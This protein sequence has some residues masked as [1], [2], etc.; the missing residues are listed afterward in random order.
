MRISS[1]SSFAATAIRTGVAWE[2]QL[3]HSPYVPGTSSGASSRI[4]S[5]LQ[6]YEFSRSQLRLICMLKVTR[7]IVTQPSS[8]ALQCLACLLVE[9]TMFFH[10]DTHGKN[11]TLPLAICFFAASLLYV[12][13]QLLV[14]PRNVSGSAFAD[15]GQQT[16]SSTSADQYFRARRGQQGYGSK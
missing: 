2:R 12:L 16:P 1:R 10:K 5:V 9:L 8:S 4:P 14:Y 15:D 13:V 7:Q 6:L 11:S 3:M